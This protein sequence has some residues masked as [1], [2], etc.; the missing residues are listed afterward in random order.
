MDKNTDFPFPPKYMS[1]LEG[2]V[3]FENM[4]AQIEEFK[5]QEI[6]AVARSGFSYAMWAAQRLKLPLGAYWPKL[7]QLFTNSDPERIVFV[8]DNILQ[9]STYNDTKKFMAQYY[10]STAWRWAVLFTDWN[11]PPE[12]RDQVI[13][14]VRLSYFAVEPFWGTM[15]TSQD[16]GVRF[17]D[18]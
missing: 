3:Y 1:E 15:K 2:M 11:T 18:E 9:G 7:S 10:P 4:L 13:H 5:P 14:G 6:V 8:D 12:I 16:Y 17:R